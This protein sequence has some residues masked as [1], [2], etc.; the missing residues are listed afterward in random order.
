[1]HIGQIH[2]MIF[3]FTRST[4]IRATILLRQVLAQPLLY[5]S[6]L[7]H[8][9]NLGVDNC[10]IRTVS[11]YHQRNF[12]ID[13]LLVTCEENQLVNLM[14]SAALPIAH[15]QTEI[16]SIEFEIVFAHD[17]KQIRLPIDEYMFSCTNAFNDIGR[18]LSIDRCTFI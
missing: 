4:A 6:H 8:A 9:I 13:K 10:Q 16:A 18:H 7:E 17:M 14:C 3:N 2:R 11:W 12:L 5:E 15:T 1:M